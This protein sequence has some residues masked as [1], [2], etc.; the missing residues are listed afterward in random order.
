MV[1]IKKLHMIAGLWMVVLFGL[2]FSVNLVF[3]SD[4]CMFAVT[5]DDVP[6]NIVILIDNGVEMK[7]TAPHGD[8]DSGVDIHPLSVPKST[9]FR[10]VLQ[11]MD[12]LMRT[13]TVSTLP[14]P[15]IIWCLLMTT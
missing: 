6:P 7:Q 2:V 3:A 5:A 1:G 10:T 11:A 13:V 12:F 4:M 8:Y 9:W 15:G 14:D